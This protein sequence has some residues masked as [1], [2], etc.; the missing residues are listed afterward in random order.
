MVIALA[1]ASYIYIKVGLRIGW[2]PGQT[3]LVLLANC[4]PNALIAGLS[5]EGGGLPHVVTR[6]TACLGVPRHAAIDPSF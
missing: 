6:F 1:A 3:D 4:E 5:T 2:G